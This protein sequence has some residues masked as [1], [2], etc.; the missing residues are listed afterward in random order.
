MPNRNDERRE[1]NARIVYWGI[2]GA[3]KSTCIRG[4]AQ[5]LRSDHRGELR[6]V[7]TGLDPTVAYEVLPIEL[8][9]VG[10]VRTR[11]EIVAVPGAPELAPTR[12]QLLDQVDGVVFVID[13]RRDRIDENLA[14]FEELRG[15]LAAYGR[16]LSEVPLVFQ[17]NKRDLA[18]PF[19]LEE[20]HRKLD[21]RGVA[22]FESVASEGKAVLQVLTTASKAV[23]RQL[24]AETA[25]GSI[26]AAEPAA[27]ERPAPPIA[28]PSLRIASEPGS[29]RGLVL[30]AVGEP[31][32]IDASTLRVPLTVEDDGGRRLQLALTVRLESASS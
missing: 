30:Q 21:M 2:E 26:R 9:Q 28:V 24:R 27:R 11:I 14:C 32:R 18:D 1:V 19:A 10:G 22:A 8:G 16:S 15:S 20:L 3:G 25:E 29:E 13:A 12:K 31:E 23:M 17:Y 4:I 5:K 6:C 7:P